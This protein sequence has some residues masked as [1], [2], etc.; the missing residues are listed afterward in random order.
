MRRYYEA[1]S[2]AENLKWYQTKDVVADPVLP[3]LGKCSGR[4]DYG[5]KIDE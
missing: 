5:Y 3:D 1:A 4:L 2:M